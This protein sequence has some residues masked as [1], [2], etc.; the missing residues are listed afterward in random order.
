MIAKNEHVKAPFL[1][2][3]IQGH[4]S[5]SFVSAGLWG[6]QDVR[7]PAVMMEVTCFQLKYDAESGQ[8][9]C[10]VQHRCKVVNKSITICIHSPPRT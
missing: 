7:A 2:S 8:F 9:T 10:N 3:C 6:Q 1:S 5:G 4:G